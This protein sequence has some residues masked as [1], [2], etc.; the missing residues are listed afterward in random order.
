MDRFIK[1]V[2]QKKNDRVDTVH[3]EAYTRMKQ[4]IEANKNIFLCSATGVGKTHLL[5]QVIDMKTCIDIQKKTS[6]EYLKDTCAPIVIEDYDAEPLVYKNL[7]DHIVEYGT[8]NGR[9]TIVTS[10]SAYMLPNF[11]VVF[12]KPLTIEQLVQIRPGTGA[13]EAATKAKGS[14]RNFLHYLE[15]YDQI[16]EFK[17]SKEYVKDILC[18]DDPFPWIDAIPEHGHI[19]DTLQENYIDSKGVDITRVTNA[20]SESDV[21]DTS[22]YNGQWSLLPYYIHSGI[23]IPKA[24]LGETLDPDNLRSGSAWTKFGNYKMRF[25][26]YN[27]IR[28][29]SG[30]RLGV[31]ELCLLKRYAELGRYDRLLDYD[32][33][34]QDFDVMNHLATT[35]KLKQRDVTNIKKGLKHAIQRRQ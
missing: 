8:I 21:F 15:N 25:K 24:S 28:R 26:K 32:I 3:E 22:I 18:T 13:V 6:V 34:P 9:S 14:I 1:I 11:E 12:V 20:L 17:S 27:E 33:T 35:S 16:D 4:L 5:H 10:I 29:K 30:N 19:C 2:S 7:I 31:E 23:R